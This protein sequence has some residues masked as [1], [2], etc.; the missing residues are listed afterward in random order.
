MRH[1]LALVAGLGLVAA[2]APAGAHCQ[3]PCGIFHDELRVQLMEEQVETIEKA[4]LQVE[5]LSKASPVNYNQIV[6]WVTT[7]DDH[8]QQLMDIVANYFL[9]QKVKAPATREGEAWDAYL[10]QLTL[11][12]GIQVAAMKTKHGTDPAAVATLREQIGKFRKAYFGEEAGH[13]HH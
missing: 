1:V 6:R 7:K 5:S 3:V 4:M 10:E 9:A 8:A 12:H 11:L 2:A 13:Q